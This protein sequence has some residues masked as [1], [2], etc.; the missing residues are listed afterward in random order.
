MKIRLALSLTFLSLLAAAPSARSVLAADKPGPRG[1]VELFTSQGCSSCPPAD[2]AFEELISDPQTVALSFHVDYWNYLGWADTMSSPEHTQ[3][4]Y[5]Y[6]AA[7]GRSSVYTPQAV[8]NG[9]S[10]LNGADLDS[11]RSGLKDMAEDGK[12]LDIPVTIRRDADGIRIAVGSGSGKANVVIA[13]FTREKQVEIA[14]G[15]NSGQSVTYRNIVSSVETIG[16]WD[17]KELDLMLPPDVLGKAGRDGGAILV[18]GE[19]KGGGLG[20]VRG[21]GLIPKA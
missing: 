18:Q 17:G 9:R 7:F 5:D 12:G 2:A 21:A 14:K 10:H 15:E 16:M 11:I 13:Y 1:V 6:A 3:R 20:P 19:G 8:L 4:Q